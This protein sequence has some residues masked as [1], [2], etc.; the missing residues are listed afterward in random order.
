MNEFNLVISKRC[1]NGVWMME[2]E[3]VSGEVLVMKVLQTL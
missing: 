3:V 2:G 1:S